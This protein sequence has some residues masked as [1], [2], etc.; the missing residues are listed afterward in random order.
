MNNLKE[1]ILEKFKIH[2]GISVNSSNETLKKVIE[3]IYKLCGLKHD[4]NQDYLAT[5]KNW[6]IDNEVEEFQAICDK[7]VL[8][9]VIPRSDLLTQFNNIPSRLKKLAEDL[10]VN[11][12][13]KEVLGKSYKDPKIYYNDKVL[14]FHDHT[15]L[16]GDIDRAFVKLNEATHVK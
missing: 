15:T 5:I 8:S 7:N 11:K 13:G 2:K 9:H 1:Y 3:R 4:S 12:R 6:V 16:L 14:I 10:I